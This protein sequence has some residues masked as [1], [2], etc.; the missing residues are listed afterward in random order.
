MR[1]W[2]QNVFVLATIEAR[3]AEAQRSFISAL[4][5]VAK[6]ATAGERGMTEQGILT[7]AAQAQ[8]SE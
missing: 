2:F 1:T 8:V 4:L 3:Q 6:R 7:P 5:E